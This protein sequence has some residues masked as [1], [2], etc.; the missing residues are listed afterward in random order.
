[1]SI[2]ANNIPETQLTELC[3]W[4]NG[5]GSEWQDYNLPEPNIL[6]HIN[7]GVLLSWFID[8]Y[9]GTRVGKEFF[10]DIVSRFLLSFRDLDIQRRYSDIKITEQTHTNEVVHKLKEFRG[11]KSIV[12]MRKPN[13]RSDTQKDNTF[14]AIKYECEAHIKSYG[15]IN[16]Q[17]LLEWAYYNFKE[18]E[19]SYIRCKVRNIFNWYLD[20]DFEP[21]LYKR[22]GLSRK[23][24]LK[25]IAEAKVLKTTTKIVEIV[26]GLKYQNKKISMRKVAELADLNLSTIQKY[27]ELLQ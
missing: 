11:L 7:R 13:P 14:W 8:G 16:H 22:N 9:V 6:K 15:I 3:F 2:I 18:K 24:H 5:N 20:R 21:H 19:T 17:Q 1:M 26:A 10:T 25:K 23:E 4:I 12:S 27:K